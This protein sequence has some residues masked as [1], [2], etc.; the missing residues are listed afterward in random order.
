MVRYEL[1]Y[2]MEG[3][4][5][6]DRVCSIT[7]PEVLI[8]GMFSSDPNCAADQRGFIFPR[9]IPQLLREDFY[10]YMPNH[11]LGSERLC[12]ALLRQRT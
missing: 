11:W 12:R 5:P 1:V 3:V 10:G 8:A 2:T 7:L 6:N 4:D 9:I